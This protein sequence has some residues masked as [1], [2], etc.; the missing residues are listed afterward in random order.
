M[1]SKGAEPGLEF[2]REGRFKADLFPGGGLAEADAPGVEKEAAAVVSAG[3]VQGIAGDLVAEAAQVDADLV[4]AAGTDADFNKGVVLIADADLPVG[5]RVAAFL[6]FGSH[7]DGLPGVPGD[8]A[9]DGAGILFHDVFYQGEVN[10]FHFPVA[11]LGL[12]AAVGFVV[13]GDEDDAAGEAVEAVDNAGAEIAAEGGKG[14]E[15]MEEGVDE[16]AILAAGTSVDRHAGGLVDCDEVRVLIEDVEREIL[17]SGAEGA[18]LEWLHFH[19]FPAPEQV[20]G[21]ANGAVNGDAAL[22]DPL[23]QAAAAVAGIAFLEIDV[24]ALWLALKAGRLRL[25]GALEFVRPLGFGG[26]AAV[27]EQSLAGD[28]G[29]VVGGEE[30]DGFGDIDGFPDT[31][32]RSDLGPG[33]GVIARFRLGALHFRGAGGDAIDA[34]LVLAQFH[35]G[36]FGEH[37]NAALGRRVI[38]QTREGQLVAAGTQSDDAAA[39]AFGNH[40]AGGL[41]RA[42]KRAAEVG[43]EHFVPLFDSE[44]K[45]GFPG[46]HGGVGD[47]D[48]NVV[49]VLVEFGEKIPSAGDIADIGLDGDGFAAKRL[50]LSDGVRG[51]GGVG[52]VVDGN[53]HAGA[54]E[55]YGD[56]F[57]NPL[58]RSRYQGCSDIHAEPRYIVI[59]LTSILKEIPSLSGSLSSMPKTM[60]RFLFSL[61]LCATALLSQTS[62][63]QL[64]GTVTDSSGAIVP[65]AAVT[66]VNE[67]T[68]IRYNQQTTDAGLYAFPSIPVGVYTLLVDSKGFKKFQQTKIVLQI[69]TPL[70]VNAALTI[71]ESTE[72]VSVEAN[73]DVLQTANATIGNVV[74]RKAIEA[75]P[76]NGRNPLNLLMY[77]PGVTQRSG[78]T[79]TVNGSRSAAVNVTIDGIEANESTAPNPTTNIFRLNPDNVQEFKVT[80]SNPSAEEGR[81]SG[82]NVSIATR[83]GTNQ[84]HGTVFEFFRNTA[85]NSSEFYANAQGTGKPII[86]LNQYGFEVGGP[87]KKNKTFFFA[88]WQGQK[89]NF[90]DP[91]DKSFG[92]VRLYTPNALTGVFRYF[93]VDQRNPFT[94]N[95]QRITQNSPLLIDQTTGNLA[96]G[97]R[98]CGAS[99]D[100]NCVASYNIV[101]SDPLRR[102]IDA[103]VKKTLGGYPAPNSFAS[104]DGLNTGN[105][106]WLSPTQVRGPQGLIRI[107]HTINDKHTLFGRY[108]GA[109]QNTL[110]GD[111]L[112]GRPQVL[113]GY[114][115]RGEVFR[116]AHNAAVGVRSVLSPRLVNEFT[117]GYS[118]F[119]FLFTQ[120]EANPLFPNAPRY[121]FNNS[122]VDYIANARTARAVNTYQ[123]INN[124]TYITGAHVYKFGGNI[125]MYQHNDQRSDVGGT[126]LTPAISLS[127]TIRPPSNFPLPTVASANAPGIAA[128]DL[129]RLQSTIN[130]LIGIPAQLSHNFIGDLRSDTFLPF[131]SGDGVSLWAQGQRVKQYNFF[132]QDEYK[133]RRNITLSYG[134]RWEINAPPTEA[135][136]RVYVPNKNIDGSQGTVSF[137]KADRWYNNWN[138]GAFAPRAA[139]T[140]APGNSNKMVLRA[141]YTM[142]FDPISTFQVTSIATAVP[143]QI[144]RCVSPVGG[145]PTAGCA[146]VPDVQLSQ[147]PNELPPPNTKPS[148]QLTPT[149]AVNNAATPARVFDPNI[150]LPTVHMWNF[151]MQ[152]EFGRGYVASIGYVGRRGT[153]LYSSR[154]LNQ[155]DARPILPSFLAMQRNVGLGGG[156]RA[157]GTLANGSPCIGATAVPLV[158]QGIT[159]SAFVNTAATSTDLSQN[160]AGNFAVRLENST[161]AAKLRANQQFAQ[162]LFVDNGADSIYHGFQATFRK[163]FDQAGLLMNAAYTLSK[164]IDNLS[165]DPIGTT[166][167]GA[168]TTTGART[169]ADSRNFQNERGRADFDQRHV[170]N[171]SGIYELPVGRGKKLFANAPKAV[172]TV[173]GGWSLNGIFTYQSG[174]PFSIRSGVLTANGTS[175]SR[176]AL[177]PGVTSLPQASLQS[178]AGVVGPV[179]FQDASQFA[180]PQPG[181]LGIG[182]NLF[183]GPSYWNLDMGISK[184]IQINERFRLTFRTEIFNA[185]NHAN[186]RN[187][188]DASVGSPA[189]TSNVFAQACCVTLATA[190]SSTTNQNGESWRVVQFALKLAF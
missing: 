99:T 168:L 85:L 190:S 156:C 128:A 101:T 134:V 48:V 120:G 107:D 130:D 62:T 97:V 52:V 5:D 4:R 44:V 171:A 167:S 169:P 32:K 70:V 21:L 185:L 103:S 49:E 117:V 83:S 153:R 45:Q 145:T 122:D 42:E 11:E 47:E 18:E 113:P 150:K 129:T 90:A 29:A 3:S 9:V 136:G 124:L 13:F 58:A 125:R 154:D 160:A 183:Q 69:N 139:I 151:T 88:S 40:A 115:A 15:V 94:L 184:G 67:A 39:V 7:A 112:N 186:F 155:I 63:T 116:P 86:K 1:G 17:G 46:L 178:K 36:H 114:P 159:T 147:F 64:S 30:E 60:V 26:H 31:A 74:E 157:D 133:F 61:V 96:A 10:L 141:G 138:W 163:R 152:R 121:T 102:Q 127:A 179:F 34:D 57:A 95:G 75:L 93:V 164:A 72:T 173:I 187:P 158:Q 2:F 110:G 76:L 177:A 148:S 8:G 78:N 108:L 38:D 65:G 37:F 140:W 59:A 77:E 33:A 188:R 174:E 165:T 166:A 89:V 176:A 28:K 189:I 123:F 54:G 20:R 14:F 16:G 50:D 19:E 6:D 180:F 162:I 55:F 98:A 172:N 82:A 91:I 144:F 79:I 80:T 43:V 12:E 135:G 182:R 149:A 87:I 68:G 131:R 24:E 41:L 109:E 56:H 104:G 161:L 27:D 100:V 66:A 142:A 73:A 81:N 71:G 175:Q 84:I 111:P 137:V 23:L 132:A 170:L 105:Y 126:T 106:A 35:R 53:I 146:S 25:H 92:T 181:G 143:G 118:R 22:L 51:T 119:F